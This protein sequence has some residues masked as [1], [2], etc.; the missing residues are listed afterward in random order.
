MKAKLEVYL[1]ETVLDPQGKTI[2]NALNN[3]GFNQIN[4]L[5]VG[6]IFYIDLNIE[7]KEKAK[8]IIEEAAEK[9]LCNKIIES[10]KIHL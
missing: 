2:K 9:L 8:K 3:L 6:K 4:D 5:R 7:E 1:K 10:Y